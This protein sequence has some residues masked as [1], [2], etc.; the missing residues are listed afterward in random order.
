MAHE[1]DAVQ[2]QS[3]NVLVLVK[4][5][6][7]MTSELDETMCVAGVRI[8]SAHNEWVRLHPVPFRD[9]TDDSK[10]AKYQSVNVTAIRHHT[11]R[12]PEPWTRYTVRS[13]PETPL[14]HSINGR[15]DD[16]SSRGS[17]KN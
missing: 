15:V 2:T 13:S 4:A 1:G 12:R 17:G 3:I 10:F 8:D 7:V 6:P 14:A 5:S 9:L 11:D 16:R